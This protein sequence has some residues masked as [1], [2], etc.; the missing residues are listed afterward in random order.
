MGD[1]QNVVASCLSTLPR[2]AVERRDGSSGK[3][4]SDNPR[5]PVTAAPR[6]GHLRAPVPTWRALASVKG[7]GVQAVRSAQPPVLRGGERDRQRGIRRR[8]LADD[9]TKVGKSND[10]TLRLGPQPSSRQ[11]PQD[12]TRPAWTR[13]SLGAPGAAK[14]PARPSWGLG[15]RGGAG[16]LTK[17]SVVGPTC[18]RLW[19]P[20]SCSSA[21]SL[22]RQ[23]QQQKR[24]RLRSIWADPSQHRTVSHTGLHRHLGCPLSPPLSWLPCGDALATVHAE[25]VCQLA[26]G[27]RLGQ[28]VAI[29]APNAYR[30]AYPASRSCSP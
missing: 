4:G 16:L 10:A 23:R 6:P 24:M 19:T 25:H 21:P 22:G 12:R 27:R 14:Y 17:E 3:W 7:V 1:C 18:S 8:G 15:G 2:R 13:P 26:T 9:D 5:R 11:V 28:S 20:D 30:A 29:L